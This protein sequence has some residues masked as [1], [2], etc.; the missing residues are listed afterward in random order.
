[1]NVK[2]DTV[3]VEEGP[4]YGGAI[5]AA[6]ADGVFTSVEDATSK[7]VRIKD[8]TEPESELVEKYQKGYEKFVKMYPALKDVYSL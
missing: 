1:M 7:I 4:A 2:V 8:T 6:V 3:E 5:L